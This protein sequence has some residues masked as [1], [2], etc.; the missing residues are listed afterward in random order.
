MDQTEHI[1]AKEEPDKTINENP[2][3]KSNVETAKD[4][5]LIDWGNVQQVAQWIGPF[6]LGL[7]GDV[8]YDMTKDTVRE[9]LGNLKRRFGK[10]KVRE[11]EAKVEELIKEVKEKSSLSDDEIVA[12]IEEV[13]KDF[14]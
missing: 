13:F 5:H 9:M 3:P 12:R 7:A 4:P 8:V 10:S 6:L 2:S 1:P 14:R 11:V